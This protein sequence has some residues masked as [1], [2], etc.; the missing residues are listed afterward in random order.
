MIDQVTLRNERTEVAEVVFEDDAVEF[1]WTLPNRLSGHGRSRTLS[2]GAAVACRGAPRFA[3]RS[4]T[5]QIQQIN[6]CRTQQI[7]P[8]ATLADNDIGQ[9]DFKLLPTFEDED[10]HS[11][12]LSRSTEAGNLLL[13]CLE[14]HFSRPPSLIDPLQAKWSHTSLC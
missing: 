4:S 8:L 3:M 1:A 7:C 12:G 10:G 9:W 6:L 14:F 2:Q 5:K 11:E 13:L